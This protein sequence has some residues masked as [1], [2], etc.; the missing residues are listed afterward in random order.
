MTTEANT[1]KNH[2][3]VNTLKGILFIIA[4]VIALYNPAEALYTGGLYIG[5][6]LL[7]S[8]ISYLYA[9]F[10]KKNNDHSKSWY[11]IEGLLD[12]ILGLL[13]ITSPTFTMEI[14]PYFVGFWVIFLG[15]SQ[16]SIPSILGKH[17]GKLKIWFY[18][19]GIISLIFGFMIINSPVISGIQLTVLLGMFF[20]AYGVVQTFASFKLKNVLL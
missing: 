20:I 8:G 19:L 13:I 10:A 7:I 16:V 14:L 17:L 18:I 15:I 3:W 2:W 4:G 9:L 6:F 11:L 1:I 5:Y 12:V